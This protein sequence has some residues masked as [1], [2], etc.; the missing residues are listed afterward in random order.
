[1][2]RHASQQRLLESIV[3]VD[4]VLVHVETVDTDLHRGSQVGLERGVIQKDR[5]RFRFLGRVDPVDEAFARIC[6][7]EYTWSSRHGRQTIEKFGGLDVDN[8]LDGGQ[9]A[10][11]VA[12]VEVEAPN[13]PAAESSNTG[14]VAEVANVL[15]SQCQCSVI[16]FPEEMALTTAKTSDSYSAIPST[17]MARSD[18]CTSSTESVAGSICQT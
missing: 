12:T 6:N 10:V 3:E 13:A 9:A 5:P 17:L 8:L 15:R 16:V 18:S 7:Q 14:T 11:L 1:M 2:E 4:M